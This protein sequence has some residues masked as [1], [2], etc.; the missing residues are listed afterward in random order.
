MLPQSKEHVNFY[1]EFLIIKIDIHI[2][3]KLFY[4]L[5][6]VFNDTNSCISKLSIKIKKK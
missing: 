3:I 6:K 5:I 4:A 1:P 2:L